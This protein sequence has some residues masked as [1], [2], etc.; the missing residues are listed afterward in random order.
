MT[1]RIS[2]AVSVLVSLAVLMSFPMMSFALSE[3]LVGEVSVSGK[4]IDGEAPVVM[5]NGEAAQSG[6]TILSGST[7][8]TSAGSTATLNFGKLGIIELAP[9][10]TAVISLS[11]NGIS[12]NLLTGKV[13]V[14]NAPE[15]SV[16]FNTPTGMSLLNAG[17]TASAA[18]DDDD[19]AGDGS[20][21]GGAW[22]LAA[23]LIGGAVGGIII[24]SN[25]DNNRVALGGGTTVVSPTR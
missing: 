14:L 25:S 23:I 10:S 7:V 17:E 11:A 15:N 13:S 4:S 16:S 2:K 3:K 21:G 8:S 9:K 24:A 12:G 18:K 19:D 1:T 20:D 6:R 22:W 5:I